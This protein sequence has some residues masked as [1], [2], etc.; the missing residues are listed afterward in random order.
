MCNIQCSDEG[1]G[2][3]DYLSEATA[4]AHDGQGLVEGDGTDALEEWLQEHKK[5]P[6]K[7]RWH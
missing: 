6:Q 5:L 1:P 4:L 3:L 2:L 7:A